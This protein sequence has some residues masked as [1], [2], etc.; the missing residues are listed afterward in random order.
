MDSLSTYIDALKGEVDKVNSRESYTGNSSAE[1]CDWL[2]ATKAR[3]SGRL[4]APTREI[5]NGHTPHTLSITPSPLLVIFPQLRQDLVL[6]APGGAG[7]TKTSRKVALFTIMF[8][9]KTVGTVELF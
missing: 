8:G 6:T 9:E 5:C 3:T 1:P 4:G 2:C 7:R